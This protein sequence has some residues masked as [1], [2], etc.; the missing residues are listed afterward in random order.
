MA[1]RSP[2]R[3]KPDRSH[4]VAAPGED[5]CGAYIKKT[6]K[7]CDRP[8]GFGTDHEG[9]GPCRL[10]GG[11]LAP[12][13]RSGVVANAELSLLVDEPVSIDPAQ[14]LLWCVT[15][16]AQDIRWLNSRIAE[17]E[18]YRVRPKTTEQGIG[19]QGPID[20]TTKGPVELN[21]LIQQRFQ[22]EERLARFSKMALDAGVADRLVRLAERMGELIAPM[23]SGILDDLGIDKAKAR[24]VVERHM[25]DIEGSA[26]QLVAA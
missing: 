6:R 22:A 8:A 9:L 15:L 19:M 14:A 23:L 13:I 21:G 3:R 25:R 20:K 7:W 16:A 5:A 10:H 26:T 12:H 18:T 2:A 11:N 4:V 24:P 1:A 17:L